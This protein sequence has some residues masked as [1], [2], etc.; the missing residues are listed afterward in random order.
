MATLLDMKGKK[1][2]CHKRKYPSQSVTHR[3]ITNRHPDRQLQWTGHCNKN[4]ITENKLL[5]RTN[6]FAPQN[7]ESLR[8][9]YNAK[10]E[11]TRGH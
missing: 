7:L 11:G 1:M 8:N 3:T 10:H 9:D 2:G 4:Y 5:A 6:K